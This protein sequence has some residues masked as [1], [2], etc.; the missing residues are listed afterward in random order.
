MV[1]TK[2]PD[3]QYNL[4]KKK[5]KCTDEYC[6][7]LLGYENLNNSIKRLL[8]PRPVQCS[9][10]FCTVRKRLGRSFKGVLLKTPH[11]LCETIVILLEQGLN[12]IES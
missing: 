9:V 3:K 10:F 2:L 4:A 8:L 7:T 1:K 5:E 6:V 12:I 11:S